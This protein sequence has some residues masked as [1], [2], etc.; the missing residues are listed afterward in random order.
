M[1]L[2][3]ICSPYRAPTADG[4][5]KNA[6]AAMVIRNLVEAEGHRAIAPHTLLPT[7]WDDEHPDDRAAALRVALG[8]LSV[9]DEVRVYG[10]PSEGML[11]E[12][13]EAERLGIPVRRLG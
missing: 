11:A 12:I 8:I 1:S 5:E 2:V 3:F 10:T 4:R 7:I 6:T 13:A 9:C